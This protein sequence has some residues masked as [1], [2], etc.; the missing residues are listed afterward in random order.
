VI[1]KIFVPSFAINPTTG[2]VVLTLTPGVAGLRAAV[3]AIA[4]QKIG[5]P[6]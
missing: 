2:Y 1:D 3:K 5:N 4:T 6:R